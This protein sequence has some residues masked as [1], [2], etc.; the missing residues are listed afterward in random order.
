VQEMKGDDYDFA[1]SS[2]YANSK[3]FLYFKLP[4]G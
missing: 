2:Q 4:L 1:Q 3:L